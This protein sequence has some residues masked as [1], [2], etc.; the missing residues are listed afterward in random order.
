MTDPVTPPPADEAGRQAWMAEQNRL[1]AERRAAEFAQRFASK[2]EDSVTA[3]APKEEGSWLDR[4]DVL[5][6][7]VQNAFSDSAAGI[8]SGIKDLVPETGNGPTSMDAYRR[9]HPDSPEP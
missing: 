6:A 3:T 9:Q 8:K 5:K 4:I 7:K 1:N 2:P